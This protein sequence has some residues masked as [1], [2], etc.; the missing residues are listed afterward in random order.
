MK[1]ARAMSLLSK[2]CTTRR[3]FL[4][5]S[6]YLLNTYSSV[7]LA[8][9]GSD[10]MAPSSPTAKPDMISVA[11]FPLETT[12]NIKCIL[13]DVDGTLTYGKLH[14]C[15]VS[16][17]TID[18]IKNAISKGFK[19]FPATGRTR[20]SMNMV[21]KGA[22][23]RIFNGLEKTPGVYQQGLMVYGAN[24]ELIWERLLPLEVGQDT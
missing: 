10:A 21:T 8:S 23:S 5:T 12:V 20:S 14:E 9:M 7:A 17:E 19:F 11:S 6:V 4:A 15:K 2:G 18:S 3:F 22:I 16:D 24:G 1:L 13:S